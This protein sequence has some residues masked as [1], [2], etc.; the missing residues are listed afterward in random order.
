MS[1]NAKSIR[2]AR[3]RSEIIST[4]MG[5]SVSTQHFRKGY[6]VIEDL[7]V[8]FV[9]SEEIALAGAAAVRWCHETCTY[10]LSLDA[11]KA[12]RIVC[13]EKAAVKAALIEAGACPSVTTLRE[14]HG[15][16]IVGA[17]GLCLMIVLAGDVVAITPHGEA[18]RDR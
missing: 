12:A 6:H 9:L 8:A 16:K 1:T 14:V 2:S 10:V 15:D 3:Y 13:D 11:A 7:G 18:Y 4:V 5:C 17:I